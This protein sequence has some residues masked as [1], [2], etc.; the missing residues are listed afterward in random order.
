MNTSFISIN[1]TVAAH[2]NRHPPLKEQKLLLLPLM[3][4][5]A[6]VIILVIKDKSDGL[7]QA[8]S[9]FV[10]VKSLKSIFIIILMKLLIGIILAEIPK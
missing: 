2:L 6:L 9:K 1:H 7:N 10:V 3:S 5:I 4:M 8:F